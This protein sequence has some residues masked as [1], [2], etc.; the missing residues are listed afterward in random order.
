[1]ARSLSVKSEQQL[2]AIEELVMKRVIG[3]FAAMLMAPY[4][5]GVLQRMELGDDDIVLYEDP[6]D[7]GWYLACNPRLG[8]FVH[9]QYFRP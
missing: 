3:L 5:S 2:C 8:R 6:D 9:V 7:P 1:M 4:D